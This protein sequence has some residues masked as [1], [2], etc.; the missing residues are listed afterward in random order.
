M[1]STY[2]IAGYCSVS[3]DEETDLINSL[4]SQM[5]AIREYVEREFPDCALKLL[6][7]GVRS[8]SEF[9]KLKCLHDM[10]QGLINTEYDIL[11]VTDFSRLSHL[12]SRGLMELEELRDHGV[13]IISIDDNIDFPSKDDWLK[14]QMQFLIGTIPIVDAS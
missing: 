1:T 5:A 14:I 11:V 4:T 12:N 6:A 2:H 8:E 9:Q 3:A 7:D 13:R 10:R